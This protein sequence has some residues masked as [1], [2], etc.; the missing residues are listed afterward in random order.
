MARPEMEFSTP[1]IKQIRLVAEAQ[2]V[3][4]PQEAIGEHEFLDDIVAVGLLPA[5][6]SLRNTLFFQLFVQFGTTLLQPFEGRFFMAA[7]LKAADPNSWGF[8][9]LEECTLWR[10]P[11]TTSIQRQCL[12][13]QNQFIFGQRGIIHPA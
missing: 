2:V 6:K 11:A 9:G 8:V 3:G 1:Q 12:S 7:K 4:H 5:E 10:Q 13:E